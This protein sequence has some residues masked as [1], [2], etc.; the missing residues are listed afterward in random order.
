MTVDESK[1]HKVLVISLSNIG[2]I[3]LTT[4]VVSSLRERFPESH[5]AV[6][7]GPKGVPIFEKSE[8]IDEVIV[9]DKQVSPWKKF[10]LVLALRRKKFD[11]VVDIRNTAI[12]FFLWPKYR[13]SFF[14]DRQAISMRQRHLDQL[15]FLFPAPAIESDRFK[16]GAVLSPVG[17]KGSSNSENRFEFFN[18]E[19]KNSA[20]QKLAVAQKGTSKQLLPVPFW[21]DN[22][23]YPFNFVIVAPG[24]GSFLKRWPLAGF[25]QVIDHLNQRGISVVLV[26]DQSER[27]LGEE[28]ESKISKQNVNL[29]GLLGLRESA[30]LISQAAIV[31]ANDSAVMHLA[32]E[33]R[34]PTV[35]IFGPTN[36]LKYGQTGENRRMVRLHLDCAPCEKAECQIERRKCLDDLPAASVIN[37]CEELLNHESDRL[38]TR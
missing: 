4:P 16:D 17:A 1:I 23:G 18:D 7:V 37:A 34:R 36:E 27:D 30:A 31:I 5:L 2:D 22:G 38:H 20:F 3:I 9:F 19:E 15:R 6:L 10:L 35:S 12:P 21:Q 11:L 24:A 26:G 13:T 14:V 32:H 28:L 29:I 25:C 8:T 33:L